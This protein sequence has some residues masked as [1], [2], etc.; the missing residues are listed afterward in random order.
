[1]KVPYT[2]FDRAVAWFRFRAAIPH[3]RPQ[4][5][6]CDIGCGLGARF[7]YGAQSRIGFGVGIDDQVLAAPTGICVVRG[8]ITQGLPFR[9]EQFDH[10]IM[11][12]VLEHLANPEPLLC[13]IYRILAP[14]GSLI[15]TWPQALLDPALHL[16]HAAGLISKE[17]ESDEHQD[18]VPVSE[19]LSILAGI[20]FTDPQHRR[21]EFGLNNLLV[22]HKP[23]Q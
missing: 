7:L 18:R 21:F 5:R 17:M 23:T 14:G 12:A 22:C 9:A 2:A 20:G 16:L 19:L 4:S 3:V 13:D 10:A 8:D 6:V 11:L 1:M 15:M